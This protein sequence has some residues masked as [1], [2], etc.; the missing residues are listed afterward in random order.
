[1]LGLL[2]YLLTGREKSS[3]MSIFQEAPALQE[4]PNTHHQILIRQPASDDGI[5]VH[6]LIRKSAFL[7]N[8]SLYCYLVLCTHFSETSVIATFGDD[9][10]GVITAYIPPQQPDTLFVWQVAVDTAAQG[11]GLA[12]RM[13]D[14]ILDR[15]TTRHIKYVETTVT[16]DNEASRATFMSLARRFNTGINESVMFDSEKHFLNLH[17]SEHKLRIGPLER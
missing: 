16:A 17:D 15:E 14:H 6:S 10:A 13:L 11:H 12:S 3:L 7:D 2:R 8:N 4:R 9:L 1:L 5:A